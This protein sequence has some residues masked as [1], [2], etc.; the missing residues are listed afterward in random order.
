MF[1][2]GIAKPAPGGGHDP[3]RT[4][5]RCPGPAAAQG[6]R[7]KPSCFSK[8]PCKKQ[9]QHVRGGERRALGLRGGFFFFPYEQIFQPRYMTETM[10][11]REGQESLIVNQISMCEC[12]SILLLRKE[13]SQNV[14]HLLF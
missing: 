6:P 9:I 8:Q 4:R 13:P 10:K 7:T 3:H 14:L 1:P 11:G 2:T 5:R 12:K